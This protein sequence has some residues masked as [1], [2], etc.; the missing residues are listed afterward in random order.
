MRLIGKTPRAISKLMRS[1][2]TQAAKHEEA[3][4]GSTFCRFTHLGLCVSCL[5]AFLCD[6]PSGERNDLTR[7]EIASF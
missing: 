7:H 6:P 5:I 1:L 3:E 4:V 2:R